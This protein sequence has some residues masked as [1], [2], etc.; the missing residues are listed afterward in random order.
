MSHHHGGVEI[1]IHAC[2]R[3]DVTNYSSSCSLLQLTKTK[4]GGEEAGD[5]GWIG[6][7][8]CF[9]SASPTLEY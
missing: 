3:E 8:R 1:G 6:A 9:A 2:E 4:L 7:M 5:L